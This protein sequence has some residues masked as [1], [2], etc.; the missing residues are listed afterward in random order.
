MEQEKTFWRPC[1]TLAGEDIHPRKSNLC[2][3]IDVGIDWAG[4]R[5]QATIEHTGSGNPEH[6]RIS[7]DSFHEL[8]GSWEELMRFH[9]KRCLG[10]AIN[11]KGIDRTHLSE[12]LLKYEMAK[13]SRKRRSLF[14]LFTGT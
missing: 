9:L 13:I 6:L 3:A 2:T 8:T 4:L 12:N 5:A 7:F 14:R 10:P 1:L 11:R